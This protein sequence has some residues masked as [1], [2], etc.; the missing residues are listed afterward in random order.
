M[1]GFIIMLEK[2]K[3]SLAAKKKSILIYV[4]EC[5]CCVYNMIIIC[6]AFQR[7]QR[8]YNL[9]SYYTML[10]CYNNTFDYWCMSKSN[11]YQINQLHTNY[12]NKMLYPHLIF[13]LFFYSFFFQLKVKL[14]ADEWYDWNFHS[15][16]PYWFPKQRPWI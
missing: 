14:R 6:I 8:T 5:R 12:S 7:I 1:I 11:D 9:N 3:H 4:L 2:K 10:Q 15:F 13:W 16:I